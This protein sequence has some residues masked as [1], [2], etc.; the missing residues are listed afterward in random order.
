METALYSELTGLVHRRFLG[1]RAPLEVS[2]EVTRRC[3]LECLHCYNNL[4]MSDHAA[5][6]YELTLEEHRRLLDQLVEAGCLWLLYTGGEIFARK[7]FLEI[8][9]EAKKRGF[10]ITLFTN[11][12]L[13]NERIADYLA[14]YRPFAIEITLYGATRE[15]YEALT[16]VPG[17]YDRCMRGIRLLLERGLPLKLKTVPTTINRQEVFDMKKLAEEKLGVEFKFDALLNPRIDCSQSPLAVRLS[18]EEVVE[19]DFSDPKR[20]SDYQRM[21]EQD[22]AAGVEPAQGPQQ[23]YSCGGG[24]H[25]CAIDPYGVMSICV[26]SHQQGYNIREGSFRAGWEGPLREIREQRRARPSICDRCQIQSLCS[27]CP[28]NGELENGDAEAPVSF[29]CQVAHLRAYA[30]GFEVPEHGPC[31]CCK[32]GPHRAELLAS[33]ER[34]KRF[35]P[36]PKAWVAGRPGSSVLNVLQP[37]SGCR[38]GGC[39]SCAPALG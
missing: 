26:I 23:K 6:V 4:P 27:M 21:A 24:K 17:S 31:E 16:Q 9:T 19:L 36:D 15:T 30:L 13:I 39:N 14:E 18:P 8:Y 1:E 38:S 20:K 37:V 33:A 7:D 34:L 11:G 32:G 3:P 2:I 29:L 35:Q 12:T 28:A 5:R 25:G 22:L 10:L